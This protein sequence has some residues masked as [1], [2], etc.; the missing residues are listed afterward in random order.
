MDQDKKPVKSSQQN[1]EQGNEVDPRLKEPYGPEGYRSG[2]DGPGSPTSNNPGHANPAHNTPGQIR[3][4]QPGQ[5]DVGQPGQGQTQSYPGIKGPETRNLEQDSANDK[6]QVE[7]VKGGVG[8]N[9][10][11][12]RSTGPSAKDDALD[13]P[14]E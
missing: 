5:Q 2:I 7:E 10:D 8:K 12:A 4:D 11:T 13:M 6:E 9:A 1:P 14:K 3:Q